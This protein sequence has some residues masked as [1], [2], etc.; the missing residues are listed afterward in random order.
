[1]EV[2]EVAEGAEPE[3][4]VFGTEEG[5]TGGAGGE[6]CGEC[7]VEGAAEGEECAF[8]EVA[9]YC[10][11]ALLGEDFGGLEEGRDVVGVVAEELDE[12]VGVWMG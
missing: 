6:V 3:F 11:V 1:M 9:G 4:A 5:E 7:G 2:A 12:T 10:V 8:E